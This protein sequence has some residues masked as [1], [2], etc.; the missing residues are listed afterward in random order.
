V[1]GTIKNQIT[2]GPRTILK[3]IGI[4]FMAASILP[5]VANSQTVSASTSDSSDLQSLN[6]AVE[7]EKMVIDQM[8]QLDKAAGFVTRVRKTSKATSATFSEGIV[9]NIEDIKEY[10]RRANVRQLR[11]YINFI[12]AHEKSHEVLFMR[13]PRSSAPRNAE[14][15]RLYECQAD[16]LAAKYMIEVQGEP[17][18]TDLEAIS[19]VLNVAFVIGTEGLSEAGHPTREQRRTAVRLGMSAGLFVK[20]SHLPPTPELKQILDG[21]AEKLNMFYGEDVLPWSYRIAKKII[22]YGRSASTEIV[23]LKDW[24]IDWDK[25]PRNPYVKYKFVYKNVGNRRIRIDME[26]QCTWVSKDDPTDTF[27]WQK[28]SVKN[29]RFELTPGQ[30]Y[31]A[32]GSMIWGVLDPN[33]VTVDF[34]KHFPRF[35]APADNSFALISFEYA[36]SSGAIVPGRIAEDGEGLAEKLARIDPN[37]AANLQLAIK[38]LARSSVDR[39]KEYL[40]GPGAQFDDST[41]YPSDSVI[42]GASDS[43]IWIESDGSRWMAGEVYRGQ[44][45]DR[46]V[47]VYSQFLARLRAA[48]PDKVP[49]AETQSNTVTSERR[50]VSFSPLSNGGPR[51]QLS[52]TK[53]KST[54]YYAVSLNIFPAD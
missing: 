9:V 22:H 42:P 20:M 44:D 28:W 8:T 7:I 53:L 21:L 51:V 31:T 29:Y 54:N 33:A 3:I 13:D 48:F 45:G 17:T 18:T 25:N 1:S 23:L 5:H 14:E 4:V 2:A 15:A 52:F 12:L 30:T 41:R 11:Q 46:A 32:E 10:A 35:I 6:P 39:F 38:N 27:R 37:S 19:D 36:D 47:D 34:S 43:W 16:I 24:V 26:F 49:A 40:T 50:Q